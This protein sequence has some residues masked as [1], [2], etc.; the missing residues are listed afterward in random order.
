VVSCLRL[1]AYLV[2]DID[3]AMQA[4]R[5]AIIAQLEIRFNLSRGTIWDTVHE[6]LGYRKVCSMCVPRQLTDEHK[7]DMQG[8]IPDASSALRGAW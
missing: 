3:V 6:C 4:D 5:C 8:V 2:Q 7:K 1:T